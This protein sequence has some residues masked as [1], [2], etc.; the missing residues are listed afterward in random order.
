MSEEEKE[1]LAETAVVGRGLGLG[2]GRARQR[3]PGGRGGRF[4][5]VLFKCKQ[6]PWLV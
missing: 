3:G 1:E 5:G 6:V 4:R 2:P